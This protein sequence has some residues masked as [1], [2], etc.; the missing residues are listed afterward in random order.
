M[1]NVIKS[2]LR[3]LE[4]IYDSYFST[5]VRNCCFLRLTIIHLA[6]VMCE[7]GAG[8]NVLEGVPPGQRTRGWLTQTCVSDDAL[9][10]LPALAGPHTLS[11]H[12]MVARYP[13]N[14]FHFPL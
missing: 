14:M 12:G 9:V 8:L 6:A 1:I 11:S 10:S 5:D 4:Q 2:Q 7:A 13:G 3:D